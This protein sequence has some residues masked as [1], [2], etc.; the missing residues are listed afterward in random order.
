MPID[1]FMGF[2]HIISTSDM[3]GIACNMC[4]YVKMQPYGV[5]VYS[6]QGLGA[7]PNG[8]N[9]AVDEAWKNTT[10]NMNNNNQGFRSNAF[11]NNSNSRKKGE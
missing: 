8:S 4:N 10:M 11:L 3:Y 9:S 1:K 2:F 6:N 7:S 5:N